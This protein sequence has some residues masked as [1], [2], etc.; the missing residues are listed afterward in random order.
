MELDA[1]KII[2]ELLEQ[3]KQQ[4]LQIAMLK[5]VVNRL[6]AQLGDQ[7]QPRKKNES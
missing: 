5:V 3:N 7:A 4:S 6:Q 2:D 1:Q